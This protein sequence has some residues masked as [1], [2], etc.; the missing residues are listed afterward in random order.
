MK[1]AI[2]I[3]ALE[4]QYAGSNRKAL[5]NLNLQ[6]ARGSFFGLLGPNGAGKT[7]LISFLCG[8]IETNSRTQYQKAEILGYDRQQ[9]KNYKSKLGYAPQEIALYPTLTV[10]ENLTYFARLMQAPFIEVAR[11]IDWVGLGDRKNSKVSELSGGMKRRLN[12]GVAL[13]NRPEL[14]ILDEPTVGIDPE[15]RNFIFEKLLELKNEG[16]TLIY[17]THYLEEV[18]KLCDQTGVLLGGRMIAIGPR[19]EIFGEGD[20]EKRYLELTGVETV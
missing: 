13:L 14:L 2:D 7:S 20:L 5:T 16:V 9:I 10:L 15:S 4:L 11:V 18:K 6:I 17:S 3:Q 19:A 8:Q 12:L 1:Y